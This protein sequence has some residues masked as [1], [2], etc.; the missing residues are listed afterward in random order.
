MKIQVYGSG[1]D[2]CKKL[3][4]N[5]ETAARNLRLEIQLENGI[6]TFKIYD[7]SGWHS[8]PR[9]PKSWTDSIKEKNDFEILDLGTDAPRSNVLKTKI[10]KYYP[11]LSQFPY[12]GYILDKLPSFCGNCDQ[13]YEIQMEWKKQYRRNFCDPIPVVLSCRM[14]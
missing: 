4:A 3:A 5:V 2:K 8:G 14:R 7:T 10:L 11:V 6:A 13:I 1:C 12:S 9:L